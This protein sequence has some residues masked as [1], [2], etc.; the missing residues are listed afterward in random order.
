VGLRTVVPRAWAASCGGR[1]G[2]LHVAH[3]IRST[4]S[5]PI[6]QPP[7]ERRACRLPTEAMSMPI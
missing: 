1:R 2:G 3:S 6:S 5:L 7:C 4:S